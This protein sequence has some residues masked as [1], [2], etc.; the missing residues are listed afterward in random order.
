MGSQQVVDITGVLID[1]H[2]EEA[3]KKKQ[4][5]T[6]LLGCT[7][8]GDH[9]KITTGAVNKDKMDVIPILSYDL[10]K[11]LDQRIPHRCPP[12]SMDERHIWLYAGARQ[13][14]DNLISRLP[15]EEI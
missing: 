10:I 4:P 11:Q 15:D 2:L 12:V 13:L 1:A 7:L 14:V 8:R 3:K 9:M 6:T 5:E